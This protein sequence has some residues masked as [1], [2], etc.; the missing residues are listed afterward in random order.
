MN[1]RLRAQCRK[2][3]V[4]A[5][6]NRSTTTLQLAGAPVPAILLIPETAEQVPAA[7]LL[8]GY[9]STALAEAKAAIQWLASHERINANAIAHGRKRFAGMIPATYY[10]RPQ[11]MRRPYGSPTSHHSALNALPR[12]RLTYGNANKYSPE[13]S[14]RNNGSSGA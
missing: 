3:V 5:K 1:A 12:R 8:H 14:S 6:V 13:K 10:R 4:P 7:L 9:G 11:P 2:A